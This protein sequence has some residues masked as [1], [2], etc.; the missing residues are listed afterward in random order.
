MG[1]M[2]VVL[3]F[4]LGGGWKYF[5]EITSAR[6]SFARSQADWDARISRVRGRWEELATRYAGLGKEVETADRQAIE[7]G[8]QALADYVVVMTT[9]GEQL[10]KKAGA[11]F[12]PSAV[13]ELAVRL[14][15]EVFTLNPGRVGAVVLT[16]DPAAQPDACQSIGDAVEQAL[17]KIGL[18]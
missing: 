3:A 5:R 12:R 14:E 6:R 8:L 13:E 11:S 1:W 16:V 15:N 4:V 18:A 17:E 7:G 9:R 2:A 10:A